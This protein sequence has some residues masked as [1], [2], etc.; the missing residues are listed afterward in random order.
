MVS[1]KR[2]EPTNDHLLIIGIIKNKL[3]TA[4][5][6]NEKELKIIPYGF[7]IKRTAS[8][9]CTGVYLPRL[10]LSDIRSY[11]QWQRDSE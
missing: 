3:F 6:A 5:N 9:Y 4:S 2:L 11:P 1:S 8:I 7:Q 10:T